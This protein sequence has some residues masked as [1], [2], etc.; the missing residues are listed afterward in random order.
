MQLRSGKVTSSNNTMQLRSGKTKA[1]PTKTNRKIKPSAVAVVDEPW[2]AK[3]L[4]VLIKTDE[5][6]AV[7]FAKNIVGGE[8]KFDINHVTK[9][10]GSI[11]KAPIMLDL[12]LTAL[13]EDTPHFGPLQTSLLIFAFRHGFRDIGERIIA[14]G[15]FTHYN[16]GLVQDYIKNCK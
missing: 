14:S 13:K 11:E 3:V 15:K 2:Y 4:R 16:K 9:F 7:E 5:P 10:F 6:L 12:Y 1:L 8:F